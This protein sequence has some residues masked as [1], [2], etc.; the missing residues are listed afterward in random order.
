MCAEVCPKKAILFVP[1]HTLGQVHRL[2]SALEYVHLQEVEYLEHGVK[3][4]LQYADI[5]DGN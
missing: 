2:M 5:G 4:T 1:E 3:K